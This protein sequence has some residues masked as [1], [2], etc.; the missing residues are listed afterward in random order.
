M[1]WVSLLSS[2]LILFGAALM[3]VNIGSHRHTV[4]AIRKKSKATSRRT[5]VLILSHQFF[6]VFFFLGYLAVFFLF[7]ERIEFASSLFVAVIFFFGAIFVLMGI[8]IQ[9]WMFTALDETNERLLQKNRQLE[10]EQSRLL[11]AND[12]LQREITIR[13]EAQKADQ[14][15]SDF[16][17][18]VSHELRTPLTSIFGFTQL[19]RKQIA[20]LE[21]KSDAEVFRK[22]KEKLATNLTI[23]SK[24]C[25]RLTRLINNVLDL[26]KIESGQLEW[27][28]QDVSFEQIL[29]A[30]T[31]AVEGLFLETDDV[32]FVSSLEEGLPAIRVDADQVTQMLVNLISNA[33]KFTEQGMIR[34]SIASE[35]N[36]FHLSVS[37]TGHGIPEESLV[38]I[39]DKFYV[40]RN[41]DTMG[42]KFL[43]TGLGLAICKEIVEH[44]GG[45]I[46][47]ESE[48]DEG[49]TFHIHLPGSI[50]V[51]R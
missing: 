18:L 25:G 41:G 45:R 21:Y 27:K 6:M 19:Q 48:V 42:G 10:E 38:N 12:R 32:M 49:T 8:T 15:K 33:F 13:V 51:S 37:D 22:T 9:K 17:S 2:A 20:S 28:D 3:L 44:Y 5:K 35:T 30:S 1:S 4:E 16:L 46:R 40:V 34:L 7:L 31:A 50:A 11:E 36:G 14:L 47:V 43:G 24:E 39:F 29:E 26:A 23:V